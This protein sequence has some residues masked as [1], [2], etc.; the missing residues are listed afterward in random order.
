MHKKVI[1]YLKFVFSLVMIIA[2]SVVALHLFGEKVIEIIVS[3]I[4]KNG[5]NTLEHEYSKYKNKL[6]SGGYE[7]DFLKYDI[8]T[9]DDNG[10][11]VESL[12]VVDSKDSVAVNLSA[13]SGKYTNYNGTSVINNTDYDI[14]SLLNSTYDKPI[15]QKEEPYILI[16]HT[17][18]SESYKN[19]GTVVDVGKRM[20]E[21]FE[22]SGYK[23][24]HLTESFDEKEFSGAYSR[25][26]ISV[27]QILEKYPTIKLVFDIHRD[28]IT[29]SE[30][31][32]Y[33]PLTVIEGKNTAQVMFVCG[34]DSKGLKHPY[35]RENLKFALDVS[36]SMG[37]NYGALSRPVNLRRDRFN[38][39][40]TKYS[41]IIEMGSEA[42]T[43]DE[44]V[45]A[46]L[47]TVD[48]IV[49]TIEK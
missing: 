44:S 29:D 24:I 21:E 46:A 34:T 14:S 11:A 47:L 2:V 42:N 3:G 43:L 27:Q 45:N 9:L 1:I 35:W 30:G 37:E 13:I 7:V 38:T 41:F 17:H 48:S 31:V 4:E 19:G 20:A 15:L 12:G 23:T 49:S 25:S 6:S 8:N 36:R 39:H 26:A 10:P 22:K 32:N 16:Y 28:S 5:F 33:K 18:T 40:F